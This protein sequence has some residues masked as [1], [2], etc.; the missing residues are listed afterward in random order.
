MHGVRIVCCATHSL[1]DCRQRRLH[2]DHG[3]VCGA[4]GP[5]GRHR[6]AEAGICA[7]HEVSA[8][9]HWDL[10]PPGERAHLLLL[11]I[12]RTLICA[13]EYPHCFGYHAAW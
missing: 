2:A 10:K 1:T 13:C 12:K 9:A 3:R 11:Q 8:P 5:G 6:L 7:H 4:P